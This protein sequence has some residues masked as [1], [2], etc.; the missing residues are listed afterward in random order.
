MLDHIDFTVVALATVAAVAAGAVWYGVMGTW[1]KRARGIGPEAPTPGIPAFALWAL[2]NLAASLLLAD[3]L[4][5]IGGASG[6][7][8]LLAGAILGAGFCVPYLA[9]SNAFGGQPFVL[10]LID[11]GHAISALGSSGFVIGAMS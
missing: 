1:W 2:G 10:T 6:P 11:S 5:D 9:M 8:G 3:L 4:A 7:G